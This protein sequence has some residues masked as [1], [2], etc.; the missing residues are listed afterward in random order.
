MTGFDKCFIKWWAYLQTDW[1]VTDGEVLRDLTRDFSV[2]KRPGL[3]GFLT[4]LVG[5]FYWHVTN[6]MSLEE[7]WLTI[8]EDCISI[9]KSFLH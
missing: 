1:G 7:D 3:N 2:L 4:L 9:I 6:E 8:V 5:L